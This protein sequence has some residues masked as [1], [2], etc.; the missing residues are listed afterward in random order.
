MKYYNKVKK[1]F[2]FIL[3]QKDVGKANDKNNDTTYLFNIFQALYP[4]YPN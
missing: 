2:S 1:G 3:K 4:G